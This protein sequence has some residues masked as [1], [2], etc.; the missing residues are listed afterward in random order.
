MTCGIIKLLFIHIQKDIIKMKVR[1]NKLYSSVY[2]NCFKYFSLDLKRDSQIFFKST[3]LSFDFF[4]NNLN[5]GLDDGSIYKYKNDK[6]IGDDNIKEIVKKFKRYN[7]EEKEQAESIKYKQ[8]NQTKIEMLLNNNQNFLAYKDALKASDANIV[9][10][11][12]SY[13]HLQGGIRKIFEGYTIND[14]DMILKFIINNFFIIEFRILFVFIM[15][16]LTS[17]YNSLFI[18][19]FN[20]IK[21]LNFL[22]EL[23]KNELLKRKL[24]LVF[25]W[26]VYTKENLIAIK[27]YI[28]VNCLN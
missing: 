9:Y 27:K 16:I 24:Y 2:D 3:V 8:N 18:K 13:I 7:M 4:D 12:L 26:H 28:F 20:L 1:N 5:I 6:K 17:V 11:V 22:N 14:L 25:K 19:D 21:H 15:I 23:I 10:A